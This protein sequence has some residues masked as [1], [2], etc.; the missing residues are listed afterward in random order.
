MKLIFTVI[1]TVYKASSVASYFYDAVQALSGQL[2]GVYSK[3]PSIYS[4]QTANVTMWTHVDGEG[5]HLHVDFQN[6]KPA[7][8]N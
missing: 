8:R 1:T 2:L 7:Q 4:V 5:D 6:E 3:G